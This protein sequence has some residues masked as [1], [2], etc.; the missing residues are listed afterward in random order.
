MHCCFSGAA[1]AVCIVECTVQQ[2]LYFSAGRGDMHGFLMWCNTCCLWFGC[3]VPQMVPGQSLVCPPPSL[4]PTP[5][6]TGVCL[7]LDPALVKLAAAPRHG[8][9][10]PPNFTL[11]GS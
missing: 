7:L 1:P 2:M 10:P 6:S 9:P 8:T 3:T 5:T 4:P 11:N